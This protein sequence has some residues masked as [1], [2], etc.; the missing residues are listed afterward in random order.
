MESLPIEIVNK[1]MLYN[2]TREAQIVSHAI[3]KMLEYHNDRKLHIPR[4]ILPRRYQG[5]WVEDD[6]SW[7]DPLWVYS[8]FLKWHIMIRPLE[9]PT[10]KIIRRVKKIST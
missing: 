4:D 6:G 5:Y 9:R 2:R 7:S 10:K 8:V 1:I 3:S